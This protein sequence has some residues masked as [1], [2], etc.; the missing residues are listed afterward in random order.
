[1]PADKQLKDAVTKLY[2]RSKLP[3]LNNTDIRKLRKQWD[4]VES[5]F[6][7]ELSN[8][9][10]SR[11]S[12]YNQIEI[13]PTRFGSLC[14][15]DRKGK[16]ISIYIRI[17]TDISNIA[18][19]ILSAMFLVPH[20]DYVKINGTLNPWVIMETQVDFLMQE[21]KI[22]K[23]FPDHICTIAGI[24]KNQNAKARKESQKYLKSLGF[25]NEPSYE[26]HQETDSVK[27]NSKPIDTI[28]TTN[29]KEL[30]KLFTTNKNKI[31]NNDIIAD[32]L[33]KNNSEEAYS[34]YAIAKTISR[35]RS[36]IEQLGANPCAI[37]A[38]RGEGY[39]LI[40]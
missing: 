28:F 13:R 29:E 12:Q 23:L 17:D 4:S 24:S 6:F 34:L 18:Y 27:L 2:E 31:I 19:G 32:I 37:Q 11:Y 22:A 1:M 15:F 14:S 10:P 16:K 3:S 21:T 35:I 30:M 39:V 36:K 40:D 25:C 33:W 20:K 5:Q 38:K 7:Q 8:I 26:Y 9:I